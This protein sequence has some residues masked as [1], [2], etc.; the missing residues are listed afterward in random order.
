MRI[1]LMADIHANLPALEA[2]WADIL[3]QKVDAVYSLGDAV[4]YYPWPNEVIE[5]LQ[6]HPI[7]C[8]RGN[9][10]QA[11][12][13]EE[14]DC[15]CGFTEDEAIR[16]GHI[17][18]RY[19]VG[20]VTAEHKAWLRG[21]PEMAHLVAG[22]HR[23]LLLHGS[24][25]RINEETTLTFPA[26]TLAELMAYERADV[27]CCAH[28]HLPGHFE[29]GAVHVVNAGTAGK[30]KLGT[31]NVNYVIV[32]VNER[33]AVSIIEVAYDHERTARETLAAGLPEK[34]AAIARTGRP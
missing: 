2:V 28:T 27:L 18:M 21:L 31:P 11:V 25:R 7:T 17:S 5:F 9:Y 29:S 30:A 34:F 13:E 20:A 1:A 3:K 22:S 10:D 8:I 12:G 14:E 33:I 4:G 23:L 26:D 19:T 24:P 16:L 15:G 6:A 32:D